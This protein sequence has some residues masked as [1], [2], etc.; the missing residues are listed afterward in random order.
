MAFDLPR[1]PRSRRFT[2]SVRAAVTEET[3]PRSASGLGQA[4][5]KATP[6]A[7]SVRLTTP[8][9][10]TTLRGPLPSDGDE[11]L[12]T[13][14]LDRDALDMAVLPDARVAKNLPPTAKEG[15]QLPVPGFR[16]RGEVARRRQDTTVV[17]RAHGGG[18]L[19]LG[20]WL[21][22]AVIAAIVSFHIAPQARE[23]LTALLGTPSRR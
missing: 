22:A 10:L 4:R 18:S 11:E 17:V 8:T 12:V 21:F 6:P 15:P 5:P 1:S 16:S 7:P 20:V 19:P 13:L 23:G 9:R 3:S 2:G 14:W